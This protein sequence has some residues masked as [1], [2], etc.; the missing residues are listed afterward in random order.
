MIKEIINKIL[1][2]TTVFCDKIKIILPKSNLGQRT[3]SAIILLILTIY[4]IYFSEALFSLLLIAVTIIIAFEWLDIIKEAKNTNKWRLIGFFYIS[5]PIWSI[6]QIRAIDPNILL[7]MFFVIWATDISAYFIGKSFKGPKL[8]P[9]ISPN[10]TWSGLIGGIISSGII[11]FMSSFL[12]A[13]GDIV[14]FV[15]ISMILACLEQAGDLIESKIK[16][17][18]NVK[19]SGSLIPGHGGIL[20][21]IDGIT[22]VA[23]IVLI[24]S[25]L[26]SY[27]FY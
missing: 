8:M 24:L 9:Q 18:F 15:I 16:R 10:K 5:I 3:I 21:R 2:I 14:F 11:G 13:N 25:T 4:A 1:Q 22:L 19:D 12:F 17:I 26:F 23:P 6:A 7:W 27:K 20:D